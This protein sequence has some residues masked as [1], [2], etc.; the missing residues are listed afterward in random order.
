MHILRRDVAES[1]NLRR[2]LNLW[3]PAGE[4]RWNGFLAKFGRSA[5]DHSAAL[6]MCI[7]LYE[8]RP[9]EAGAFYE[10]LT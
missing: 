3:G 5:N 2:R 7:E 9:S 4:T 10:L 1:T 8:T 6:C